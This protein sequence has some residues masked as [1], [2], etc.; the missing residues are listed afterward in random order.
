M[1]EFL[2]LYKEQKKANMHDLMFLI[3]ASTRRLIV[4]SNNP[5]P[6]PQTPHHSLQTDTDYYTTEHD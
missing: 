3:Y 4:F 6:H 1:F 5:A 2:L